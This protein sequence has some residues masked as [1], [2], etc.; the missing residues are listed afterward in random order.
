MTA[1]RIAEARYNYQLSM[2]RRSALCRFG[3]TPSHDIED[4]SLL[5]IVRRKQSGPRKSGLLHRIR[6]SL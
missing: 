4:K 3:L 6:Q 1:V 2:K 5:F